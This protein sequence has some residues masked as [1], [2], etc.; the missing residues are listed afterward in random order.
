MDI[1][2]RISVHN[3]GMNRKQSVPF[4]FQGDRLKDKKKEPNPI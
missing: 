3:Q 1:K 4:L 2:F